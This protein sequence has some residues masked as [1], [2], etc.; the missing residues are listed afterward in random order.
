MAYIGTQHPQHKA[1]VLLCL[2]AGK[3]VLCEK[4]MGVNAAEVREMVA[5]A[6]S[7]GVFLMEVRLRGPLRQPAE[8]CSPFRNVVARGHSSEEHGGAGRG[9]HESGWARRELRWAPRPRCS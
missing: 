2:A 5:E 4:P 6:R 9:F 7:R 8:C 3:A 1:V